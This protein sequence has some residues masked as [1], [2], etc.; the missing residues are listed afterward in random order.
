VP[1]DSCSTTA[2][3]VHA[4]QPVMLALV[5]GILA[6]IGKRTADTRDEVREV[7]HHQST[8]DELAEFLKQRPNGID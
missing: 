8:A 1:L 7:R 6:V 5:T 2:I 4:L 3:W